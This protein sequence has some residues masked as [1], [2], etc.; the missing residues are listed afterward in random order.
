MFLLISSDVEDLQTTRKATLVIPSPNPPFSVSPDTHPCILA[1]FSNAKV[2]QS[3]ETVCVSSH[4]YKYVA[5]VRL[6]H[7]H[8][9]PVVEEEEINLFVFSCFHQCSTS[10]PTLCN[11]TIITRQ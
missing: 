5:R 10:I 4:C 7:C 11:Q 3:V 1:L 9:I 8:V 6:A 2:S